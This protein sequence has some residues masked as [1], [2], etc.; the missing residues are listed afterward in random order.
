ME[1][2]LHKEFK[3]ILE[4]L[5]YP[6]QWQIDAFRDFLIMGHISIANQF[7]KSEELEKNYMDVAKRYNKEQLEKFAK[8]LSI[9]ITALNTEHQDFLGECF[10]QCN[11]G[12]SYRGQFFTPYH[13]SSMMAKMVIPTDGNIRGGIKKQGYFTLL[14]PT[15]GSGGMIIA[16]D[17]VI[18]KSGLKKEQIMCVQAQDIDR[19]CFMM[20]YIQLSALDIPARVVLGDTLGCKEDKV[21][22]TPAFVRDNWFERFENKVQRK[23][24]ANNPLYNDELLE[25]FSKGTLF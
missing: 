20:T 22:Y 6:S 10:M 21:L 23:E 24:A 2:Q 3:K 14:E 8:L 18:T 4:E 5:A 19:L 1:T 25:R 9:T 11:M 12:N 15:C 13:I 17:E 16:A 7:Y